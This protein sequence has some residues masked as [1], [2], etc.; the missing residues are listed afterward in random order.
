MT[1][2]HF[3]AMAA[4]VRRRLTEC[5]VLTPADRMRAQHT[6]DAFISLAEWDNP[7]FNRERFLVAC[8]LEAN[9]P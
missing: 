4:I 1:R 5:S 6:A 8:G 7:R 9:Q 2:K 3:D